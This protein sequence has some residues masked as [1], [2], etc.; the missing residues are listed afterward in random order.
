MDISLK[1]KK[2]F[3]P[4]IAA[5]LLIINAIFVYQNSSALQTD[6]ADKSEKKFHITSDRLVADSQKNFVAFIGNIKATHEDIFISA[7]RLKIFYKKGGGKNNE[8]LSG[9]DSIKKIIATGNVKIKLEN[10]FATSEKAVYTT[11]TKLIVLTG[12][13][14]KVVNGKNTITGN[15]I[16]LNRKTKHIVVKSSEKK[17]V[18]AVLYSN[19]KN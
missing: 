10:V 17:S 11:D 4:I 15:K 12:K 2:L 1:S 5:G 18:E 14:P 9:K 13:N 8:K 16:I 6:K 3:I 7:D 19:Q